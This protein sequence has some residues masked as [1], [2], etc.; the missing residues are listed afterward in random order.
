MEGLG[1]KE[2]QRPRNGLG[3]VWMLFET[4]GG[5]NIK[6]EREGNIKKSE[7]KESGFRKL[8]LTACHEGIWQWEWGP[9]NWT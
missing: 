8:H 3:G 1:K 9:V 4:K 6:N 7:K 5:G 2:T